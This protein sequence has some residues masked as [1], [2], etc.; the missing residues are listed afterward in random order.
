[1]E[2]ELK[3]SERVNE[4]LAENASIW[5]NLGTNSKYDLKTTEAA[6]ARWQKILQEITSI[7]NELGESLT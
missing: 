4:L 3:Y 2:Q 5:A 1:M 7:D 6:N